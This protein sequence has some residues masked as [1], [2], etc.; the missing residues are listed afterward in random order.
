MIESQDKPRDMSS[1]RRMHIRWYLHAFAVAAVFVAWVAFMVSG[2]A[3]LVLTTA[4]IVLF[5]L[6]E[7]AAFAEGV[8][9]MLSSLWK[10]LLSESASNRDSDEGQ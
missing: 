7:V 2:H 4:C 6:A 8:W 1:R 9:W 10:W 5:L 3:R